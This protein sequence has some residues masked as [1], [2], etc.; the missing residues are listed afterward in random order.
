[1][2]AYV[3]ATVQQAAPRLQ[4]TS[5]ALRARCRR[6]ARKVGRD[7]VA[8]LADGVI[9]VKFGRSWRIRFPEPP[10]RT[11]GTIDEPCVIGRPGE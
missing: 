11:S 8:P 1:M 2:T 6:C 9:A 3:Y 10:V 5:G 7:V 4:M